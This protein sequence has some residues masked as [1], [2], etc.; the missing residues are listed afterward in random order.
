M[1]AIY[2]T[3]M[4]AP[5]DEESLEWQ[6]NVDHEQLY[7][8][9]VNRRDDDVKRTCMMNLEGHHIYSPHIRDNEPPPQRYHASI[10]TPLPGLCQPSGEYHRAYTRTNPTPP[11]LYMQPNNSFTPSDTNQ[12]LNETC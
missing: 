11:L 7:V 3:K 12:L 10:E 5:H 4:M 6:R 1:G 8:D 2:N 9:N